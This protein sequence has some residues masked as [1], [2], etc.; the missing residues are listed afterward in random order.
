MIEL[1]SFSVSDTFF[2]AR[3]SH[4]GFISM[5]DDIFAPQKY[6]RLFILKGGP[7]T[8]KSTLLRGVVS[9]ANGV[10]IDATAV[11]CSS[12]VSSLDGVILKHKGKRVAIIDGTA[13]HTQDPI[14]PGAIDEIVNLGEGFDNRRLE[15]EKA[16]VL[17]LSGQKSKSYG[18]AYRALRAAKGIFDYIWYILSHSGLYHEADSIAKQ[19]ISTLD[20]S[21]SDTDY[22]H[23]IYSAFGKNGDYR[24]PIEREKNAVNLCGD[25]LLCGL[26]LDAIKRHCSLSGIRA[27]SYPHALDDR[28]TERIR[29]GDTIIIYNS[30]SIEGIDVGDYAPD[31]HLPDYSALR[32]QYSSLLNIAAKHFFE[33][34]EAHRLLEKIYSASIDFSNNDMI[35]KALRERIYDILL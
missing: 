3:N 33:A 31:K 17:A 25:E 23:G 15:S 34:S 4:N 20:T 14:Y 13:P 1:K 22:A 16:S 5:F 10:G 11:L 19:I 21:K 35:F 9:S 26:I 27:I 2:G 18:E 29:V 30:K 32:M 7:G 8:G 6:E 28:I 12:D 24:L